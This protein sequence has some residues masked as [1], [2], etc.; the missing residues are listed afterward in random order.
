MRVDVFSLFADKDDIAYAVY[1]DYL[2]GVAVVN[3]F[4]FG[5]IGQAVGFFLF[6]DEAQA[7]G[8]LVAFVHGFVGFREVGAGSTQVVQVFLDDISIEA[9]CGFDEE[10]FFEGY[11]AAFHDHLDGV[12]FIVH[13]VAHFAHGSFEIFA[14]GQ[15][16]AGGADGYLEQARRAGAFQFDFI[17]AFFVVELEGVVFTCFGL[18]CCDFSHFLQGSQQGFSFLGHILG[19]GA[20]NHQDG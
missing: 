1:L 14:F 4:L 3:L 11:A 10:L 2:Y 5:N 13:R 12:A 15:L 16:E 8:V 7:V 20:G 19:E 17:V 6:I 9:G 18:N